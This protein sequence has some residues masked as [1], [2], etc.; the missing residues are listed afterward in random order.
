MSFT[1][2]FFVGVGWLG[3]DIIFSW[4]FLTK[5]KGESIVPNNVVM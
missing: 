3:L 5:R 4:D 1:K 2:V